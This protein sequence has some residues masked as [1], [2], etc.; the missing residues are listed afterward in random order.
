MVPISN[1]HTAESFLNSILIIATETEQ[2]QNEI[3]HATR[4]QAENQAFSPRSAD[5]LAEYRDCGWH[6]Q[7]RTLRWVTFYSDRL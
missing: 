4:F 5:L 6:M 1:A 2:Q 3:A 7:L